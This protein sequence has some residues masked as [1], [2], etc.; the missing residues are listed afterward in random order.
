M[1]VAI[2]VSRAGEIIDD[3]FQI[4]VDEKIVFGFGRLLDSDNGLDIEIAVFENEGRGNLE[5]ISERVIK[6]TLEEIVQAFQDLGF[7]ILEEQCRRM[8][9][10]IQA[11]LGE[12]K[13]N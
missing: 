12:K 7:M 4:P 8:F 11:L 1:C 5:I 13:K 3:V 10:F 9:G 6:G 2:V